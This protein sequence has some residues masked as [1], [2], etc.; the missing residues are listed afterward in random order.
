MSSVFVRQSAVGRNP[1]GAGARKREAQI[2]HPPQGPGRRVDEKESALQDA[3]TIQALIQNLQQTLDRL[4]QEETRVL[5]WQGEN[6]RLTAVMQVAPLQEQNQRIESLLEIKTHEI[7]VLAAQLAAAKTLEDN[8]IDKNTTEN[9]VEIETPTSLSLADTKQLG[10]A[11][12]TTTQ[13]DL[14]N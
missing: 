8:T 9:A 14:R 7:Q 4:G 13:Q 10:I 2:L 12:E 5:V 11:L 6:H 1:R 3:T